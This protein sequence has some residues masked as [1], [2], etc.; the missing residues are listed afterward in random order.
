[1]TQADHYFMSIALLE[2]KKAFKKNEVPIGC[3]LVKDGKIIS[4]AHNLV[5]KKQNATLHAEM[6]CIQK[7][8]KKIEN[9][10]LIDCVLYTTLEPCLM[11]AGAILLSRI[12]KVVFAAKDLRHGAIISQFQ[13]FSKPHPIHNPEFVQGPFEKESADLLK[14]F[15]QKQRKKN[16]EQN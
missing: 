11:C 8:T 14:L 6:L 3:V 13:I 16:A 7:A 9:F 12:K 5:E 1:M 10:R 2:A 4:K 15:F